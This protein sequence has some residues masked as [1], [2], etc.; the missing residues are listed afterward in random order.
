MATDRPMQLGMIGLGRMGADLV[1]RLMRDGHR[2]VAYD[3]TPTAV[4]ELAGEG[5]TGATSLAEFVDELRGPVRCGSWSPRA[6]SSPPSTSW[7]GCSMPTTSSSTAAIPTTAT[8]LPG[9]AADEH[10]LHYVDCGTSGGVWGLDA[11]TA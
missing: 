7:W 3:V 8:T 6:S 9:Q 2:C 10:K 11:V 4:E 1:R 5:A